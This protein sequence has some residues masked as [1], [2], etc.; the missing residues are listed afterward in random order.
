M[1]NI[2]IPGE[3]VEVPDIPYKDTIHLTS[4][5]TAI[6]IA[7]MQNDFI[8]QNGKLTVPHAEETVPRISALLE[9]ARSRG[10]R[11]AFSQDTMFKDDP[12]F[13]IWG[14]HCLVDTW[15]WEIVDE[16]KPR[17]NERIVLKNRYDAFY[18]T[19]LDHFLS[20]V[21]KVKNVIVVGTV[22]NICVLHTAASAGI[23][24]FHVVMPADCISAFTEFDQALA[25]RQVSSLYNGDV[26]KTWENIQFK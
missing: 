5:E 17:E 21:W 23:R 20:H 3:K 15:G 26:L 11:L 25:L 1:S 22:S 9:R 18:G 19:W 7:D 6:V 13:D 12:E 8:K 4:K 14:E 24:W 10:V 2:F 16:L